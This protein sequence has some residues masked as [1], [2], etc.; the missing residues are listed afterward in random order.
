MYKSREN[1]IIF[2][3]LL[4]ITSFTYY[5]LGTQKPKM[6]CVGYVRCDLMPI[7]NICFLTKTYKFKIN[8]SIRN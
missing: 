7:D 4:I 6:I 1:F 8:I 2:I 5:I 3:Y